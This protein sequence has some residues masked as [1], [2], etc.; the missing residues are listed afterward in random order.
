MNRGA[1]NPAPTPAEEPPLHVWAEPVPPP[2][3]PAPAPAEEQPL[4]PEAEVN[5]WL[6][7]IEKLAPVAPVAPADLR[8]DKAVMEEWAR[9][10]NP[11]YPS[12]EPDGLPPLPEPGEFDD[13]LKEALGM[14]DY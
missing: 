8:D 12:D 13:E 2:P 10:Q 9:Y 4:P 5:K 14:G 7:E 3:A 6:K 1:K 11:R